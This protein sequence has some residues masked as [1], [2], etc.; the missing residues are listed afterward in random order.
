MIDFAKIYFTAS[1]RY[2][3]QSCVMKNNAVLPNL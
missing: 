3:N 2:E 1:K